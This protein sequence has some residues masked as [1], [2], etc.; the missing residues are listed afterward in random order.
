MHF[1][2]TLDPASAVLTIVGAKDNSMLFMRGIVRFSDAFSRED[3]QQRYIQNAVKDLRYSF[4][5]IFAKNFFLSC[6]TGFCSEYAS[7]HVK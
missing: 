6:L 2:I 7:V 4:S 5:T 1:Q 3:L